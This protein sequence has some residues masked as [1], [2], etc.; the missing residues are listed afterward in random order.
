M[1]LLTH[2][3]RGQGPSAG[4]GLATV[5]RHVSLT[6]S[7]R[8]R[9]ALIC[10]L[11]RC[12]LPSSWIPCR[13]QIGPQDG[14]HRQAVERQATVKAAELRAVLTYLAWFLRS[15]TSSECYTRL[16]CVLKPDLA[17]NDSATSLFSSAPQSRRTWRP[18]RIQGD[19]P[20]L[21]GRLSA[22]RDPPRIGPLL[23][24]RV[25]RHAVVCAAGHRYAAAIFFLESKPTDKQVNTGA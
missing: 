11:T 4:S 5:C 2:K 1:C 24:A 3:G 10:G 19:H 9:R 12:S 17:K 15:L 7:W 8:P 18:L 23:L 20:S 6:S 25:P 21:P 14:A 13:V 22:G 16:C